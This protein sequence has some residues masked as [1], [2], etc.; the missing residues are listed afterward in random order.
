MGVQPHSF[1]GRNGTWEVSAGRRD[2]PL[3]DGLRVDIA[4]GACVVV[5]IDWVV[6]ASPQNAVIVGEFDSGHRWPGI[7][8]KRNVN[9]AGMG[10]VY[11]F[12]SA[13]SAG[14]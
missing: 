6:A 13:L 2:L 8:F 7:T 5:F 1:A 10:L 12:V 11:N 9:S 14:V 3:L 4:K